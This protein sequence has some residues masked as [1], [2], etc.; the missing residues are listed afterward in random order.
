MG[1][2]L[3]TPQMFSDTIRVDLPGNV[4]ALDDLSRKCHDRDG[5]WIRGGSEFG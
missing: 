1:R 5:N 2:M 4:S 3:V